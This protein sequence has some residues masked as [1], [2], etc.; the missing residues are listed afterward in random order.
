MRKI[1]STQGSDL[2]EGTIFFNQQYGIQGGIKNMFSFEIIMS[3]RHVGGLAGDQTEL[4]LS[5]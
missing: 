2:L 5:E 4:F 1:G 3:V